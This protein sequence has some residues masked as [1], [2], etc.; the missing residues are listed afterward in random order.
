MEVMDLQLH[1]CIHDTVKNVFSESISNKI[2]IL[3]TFEFVPL[4]QF[5]LLSKY[6]NTK[7]NFITRT[8]F[9]ERNG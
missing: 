2:N 5:I 1:Y 3:S 9:Y 6:I 8:L 7:Q 4:Y